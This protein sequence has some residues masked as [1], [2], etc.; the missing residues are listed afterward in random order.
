MG[1]ARAVGIEGKGRVE[2]RGAADV[3]HGHAR[4]RGQ[5]EPADAGEQRGAARRE[6]HRAAADRMAAGRPRRRDRVRAASSP[7][8]STPSRAPTR[9]GPARRE[10]RS[11]GRRTA[12]AAGSATACLGCAPTRSHRRG[13][14][15]HRPGQTHAPSDPVRPWVESQQG[16]AAADPQGA[17]AERDRSRPPNRDAGL[18]PTGRRIDPRHA[19]LGDRVREQPV[20]D[21]PQRAGAVRERGHRPIPRHPHRIGAAVCRIDTGSAASRRRRRPT[22]SPHRWSCRPA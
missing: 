7:R 17:G 8:R 12:R 13:P 2:R 18:Q 4:S 10:S 15:R 5:R 22:R 3:D 20:V 21:H 14:R 16:P 9:S 6:A 11:R 1:H 19:V